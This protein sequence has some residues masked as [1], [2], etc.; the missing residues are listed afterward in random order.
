M[1]Q[2]QSHSYGLHSF[3]CPC[4]LHSSGLGDSGPLLV[5]SLHLP[6]TCWHLSLAHISVSGPFIR[7][8]ST[9]LEMHQ[10]HAGY[11]RP[12]HFHSRALIQNM[13]RWSC[14]RGWTCHPWHPE[15][16]DT[17]FLG[18]SPVSAPA[19][20]CKGSHGGHWCHSVLT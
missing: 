17:G 6:I 1:W 19:C 3:Q 15:E 7:F 20:H 18:I 4:S 10:H 12:P 11:S 2:L 8:S 5:H 14:L 16:K 13:F 9:T